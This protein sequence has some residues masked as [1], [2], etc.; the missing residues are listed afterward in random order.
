MQEAFVNK[1]EKS[2]GQKAFSSCAAGQ[3]DTHQTAAN[4]CVQRSDNTVN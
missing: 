4:N 1:G 2:N 3:Y